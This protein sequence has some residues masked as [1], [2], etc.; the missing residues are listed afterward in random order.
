MNCHTASQLWDEAR[1]RTLSAADQVLFDQH[2]HG[3]PRCAALWRRESEMLQTLADD[4]APGDIETFKFHVMRKVAQAHDLS[5]E[6]V[7]SAPPAEAQ[8]DPIV[9]K[10]APWAALAA[11][12]ALVISLWATMKPGD[13]TQPKPAAPAP[14]AITTTTGPTHPVSVL[15]QDLTRGIDQPQRLRESIEKTTSYL[16]LNELAA[17]LQREAAPIINEP[18]NTRG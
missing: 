11:A 6:P 7:V 18:S 2:L 12:V 5:T 13:A 16:N 4:A 3:C 1:D 17:L 14:V 15:V 8:L 9:M 10:L